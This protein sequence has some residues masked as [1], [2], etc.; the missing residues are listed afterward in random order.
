MERELIDTKKN[1]LMDKFKSEIDHIE[2]QKKHLTFL[3]LK[4]KLVRNLRVGLRTCVL[5]CPYIT[6]ASLVSSADNVIFHATPFVKD[7]I[8]IPEHTRTM[9]DNNGMIS[10]DRQYGKYDNELNQLYFRGKWNKREDGFYERVVQTYGIPY[11]SYEELLPLLSTDVDHMEL[12]LGHPTSSFTE[13]Q[14]QLSEE[15]INQ[16]CYMTA[17]IYTTNNERVTAGVQSDADNLS[18][19]LIYL[20]TTVM[21]ESFVPIVMKDY[22]RYSKEWIHEI[23]DQYYLLDKDL[24]EKEL[25]IRIENNEM[26][27]GEYHGNRRF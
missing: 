2:Y 23:V 17:T 16:P 14:N 24:L 8:S 7:P 18:Y 13:Y 1:D 11:K 22:M 12:I 20:L 5:L 3:N 19:T 26:L 10:I 21:L 6:V 25:A 27:G 9:A 4:T 15:E